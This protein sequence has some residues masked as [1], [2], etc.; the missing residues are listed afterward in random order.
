MN[1]QRDCM[2]LK[3]G[4]PGESMKTFQ[5][6]NWQKSLKSLHPIQKTAHTWEGHVDGVALAIAL[7]HICL[8]A[9]AWVDA[10]L[11]RADEQD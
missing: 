3:L 4:Q 2:E 1:E 5:P 6:L 10:L 8:C 11:V 9:R 7:A